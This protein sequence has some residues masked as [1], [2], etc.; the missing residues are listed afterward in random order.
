MNIN[1]LNELEDYFENNPTSNLFPILSEYYLLN[2]K[3]EKAEKIC[4]KGLK[5]NP[6]SL[7]GLYILSR[8]LILKKEYLNSEKILKKIIK[9]DPKFFNAYIILSQIYWNQN[10]ISKLK[11]ILKQ[12]LIFDQKNIYANE[13]LKKIS[14][15]IKN[16]EKKIKVKSDKQEFS[17]TNSNIKLV[18]DKNI[19]SIPI[20]QDIATFTMVEIFKNQKLYKEALGVL[21]VMKTKKNSDVKEI[22]TKQIEL[23]EL[24]K[25]FN[26]DK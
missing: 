14:K 20:T 22:K 17:K 10:E 21:S 4:E 5:S 15:F 9:K 24:L 26:V 13:G 6:N 7:D 18:D 16:D 12:L 8:I 3:I 2:K 11:K 23:I 19:N 1:N 25:N